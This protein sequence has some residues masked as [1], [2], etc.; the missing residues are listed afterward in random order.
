MK[1]RAFGTDSSRAGTGGGSKP[2]RA[3]RELPRFT[4]VADVFLQV[5][6]GGANR[7][8]MRLLNA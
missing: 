3:G 6:R 5:E 4:Y 7:N 1:W 8:S 2:E